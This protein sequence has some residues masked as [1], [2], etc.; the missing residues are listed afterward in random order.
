[1]TLQKQ[2]DERT[3]YVFEKGLSKFPNAE[4]NLNVNKPFT[5]L[6]SKPF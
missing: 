1:M 3:I 2:D 6:K 5:L 4:I